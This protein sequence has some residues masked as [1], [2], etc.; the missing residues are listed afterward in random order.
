MARTTI[1]GRNG[2]PIRMV[3]CIPDGNVI[4][5]GRSRHCPQLDI[6]DHGDDPLDI[7]IGE[8]A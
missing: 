1:L 8:H 6:V 2:S 5:H 3:K 7:R 4:S